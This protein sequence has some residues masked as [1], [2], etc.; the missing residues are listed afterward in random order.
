MHGFLKYL[1][2]LINISGIIKSMN[3]MNRLINKIDNSIDSRLPQSE[4]ARR[5]R[6]NRIKRPV[7]ALALTGVILG[8]GKA[9]HET[10]DAPTFS[11]STTTYTVQPGEGL[12]NAVD[13]IED[14]NSVDRRDAVDYVEHMPQNEKVL[15]DG[16]QVDETIVVPVSI[17]SN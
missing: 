2:T 15:E 4:E 9:V 7:A 8:G 5:R 16:L 6:K 10:Y 11:E 3:K 17:E 1:L 13:G 12:W 14:L